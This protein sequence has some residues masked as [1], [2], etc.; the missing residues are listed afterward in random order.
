MV[1]GGA[2]AIFCLAY[3][4]AWWS[5]YRLSVGYLRDAG[6]SLQAGQNLN[7]LVGYKAFDPTSRRY[8]QHGGYM[9]VKGIWSSSYAVPVPGE[10]QQAQQKIDEI[11]NTRLTV[12]EAEQFVQE[13]VGQTNPYLGI[14]YLRLGELYEANGRLQEA[15]DI[16]KSIPSLFVDD[17]ALI[18]RARV[19]LDN[20]QQKKSSS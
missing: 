5:A 14:I 20:L 7:A 15:E 18:E 16:Y 6:D 1:L 3:L 10:V 13:H 2:V 19:D 9:Q 11:I 17:T 12:E 4:L 8:T